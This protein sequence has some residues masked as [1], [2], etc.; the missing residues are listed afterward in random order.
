MKWTCNANDSTYILYDF[1]YQNEVHVGSCLM[2]MQTTYKY[3][4]HIFVVNIIFEILP[5]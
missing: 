5:T 2:I 1:F 3:R 4:F